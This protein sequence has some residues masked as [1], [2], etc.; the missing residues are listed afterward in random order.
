M[1]YGYATEGQDLHVPLRFDLSVDPNMF[2]QV[3]LIFR[4]LIKDNDV[5]LKLDIENLP[6]RH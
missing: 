1:E 2:S 4:E 3:L 6:K 5:I